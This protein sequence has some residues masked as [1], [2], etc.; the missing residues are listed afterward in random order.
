MGIGILIDY[1][2]TDTF[3]GDHFSN[4]AAYYGAGLLLDLGNDA[5]I[6][7]SSTFSQGFGGPRGFGLLYD[8]SGND[9][10]RA[11]GLTPSVY[12]TPAVYVSF[13]QGIGFGL[14]HYDSGGIGILY[15]AQGN[16]RYEGGEFSQ[17]LSS[18]RSPSSRCS[19]SI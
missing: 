3:N 1:A 4:G 7:H 14:R 10:Y 11:N 17:A 12:G 8:H 13:S 5:D 18:R 9:L 6:Y 2:G 16:D 15:D 19:V